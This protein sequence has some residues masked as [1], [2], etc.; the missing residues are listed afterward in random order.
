MKKI[1]AWIYLPTLLLSLSVSAQDKAGN[2]GAAVVC[3]QDGTQTIESIELFDY[4]EG[5]KVFNT[6]VAADLGSENLSV[7]QK[8]RLFAKRIEAVDPA[9]AKRYLTVALSIYSRLDEILQ[10]NLG[11]I[12]I[13]DDD[14]AFEPSLPCKK[15]LF[16]MQILN[17]GAGEGRFAI[18]KELYESPLTSNTTRAGIIL[19]ETIYRETIE[20]GANTSKSARAYHFMVAANLDGIASDVRAYSE[21]A[22]FGNGL[23][24]KGTRPIY[25]PG[26]NQLLYLDDNEQNKNEMKTLNLRSGRA[27]GSSFLRNGTVDM[28]GFKEISYHVNPHSNKVVG[29]EPRG[30]VTFFAIVFG[31]WLKVNIIPERP[32]FEFDE[33]QGE[34]TLRRAK[35]AGKLRIDSQ[36]SAAPSFN[37]ESE[38]DGVEAW[39]IEYCAKASSMQVP[40]RFGAVITTQAGQPVSLS[41]EAGIVVIVSATLASPTKLKITGSSIERSF[42]GSVVFSYDGVLAGQLEVPILLT[43]YGLNEYVTYFDSLNK[44]VLSDVFEAPPPGMGLHKFKRKF[45]Q[46]KILGFPVKF[47]STS[48][49][50]KQLNER[51]CR[52]L[53][54]DAIDVIPGLGFNR[55]SGDY[56]SVASSKTAYIT[57]QKT[58]FDL[59]AQKLVL[60]TDENVSFLTS[61]ECSGLLT[62]EVWPSP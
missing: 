48:E 37:C 62:Y 61:V 19:H 13:D 8:I 15:E 47:K 17:P 23:W 36:T 38:Y 9:R 60:V 59:D 49:T 34:M 50:P 51:F 1:Y 27:Y 35:F 30:D 25:L 20:D 4:W 45:T 6:T 33:I 40:T 53:S 5:K 7:L 16:A 39:G 52:A 18:R 28:K 44:Y 3:Y 11:S 42:S 26:F 56:D 31:Q 24:F 46:P 43:M 22:I 14:T 12:P 32:F 58:Y 55:L 54:K 2:G 10:P 21:R 29:L 57:G 41:L